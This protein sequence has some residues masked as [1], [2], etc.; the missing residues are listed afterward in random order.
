MSLETFLIIT[1]WP[2]VAFIGFIAALF[3]LRSPITQ[4]IG[5]ARRAGFGDKSIDFSPTT[6]EQQKTLEPP[7]STAV[8]LSVPAEAALPQPMEI[9]TAIE[10]EMTTALETSKYPPEIQKAWLIRAVAVNRIMRNH[11]MV[12]RLILGSQ[13][14]LLLAANS[15]PPPDMTR[16]HQIFDA[17]KAAFPNIYSNF[18]FDA[19][20]HYLLNAGLIKSEQL[21]VEQFL[22]ITLLGQD[23]LHYLVSNNLTNRKVG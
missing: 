17:A 16:T 13:I 23:F 6:A 2:L 21:G 5:R 3:I 7:T 20:L 9:Y 12:Y 10:N 11:E 19:W 22:R 14:E 15:A 18:S 1:I 4:L 8:A